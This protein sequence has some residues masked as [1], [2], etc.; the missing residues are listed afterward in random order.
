MSARN[1]G[2]RAR[3]SSRLGRLLEINPVK[4]ELSVVVLERCKH[5][6]NVLVTVWVDKNTG[7]L[8]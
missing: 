6:H 3:S 4:P 1:Y 8:F 2:R 7:S 5:V